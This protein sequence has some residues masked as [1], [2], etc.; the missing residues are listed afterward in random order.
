MSFAFQFF[1][2]SH[3]AAQQALREAYAPSAVKAVVD[4]A[5]AVMPWRRQLH[6][7]ATSDEKLKAGTP[8]ARSRV[9][10][11]V[12]VEA[13]GHLCEMGESASWINNFKVQPLFE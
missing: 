6:T 5:L 7:I 4:Q 13:S 1:A 9:F 10:V 3:A 12:F 8:I 2:S 11:G